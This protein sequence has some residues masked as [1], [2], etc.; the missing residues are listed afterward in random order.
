MNYDPSALATQ[1]DPY[2][3][4]RW[5]L[6]QAPVYENQS[7]GFHALSRFDDVQAAFRDWRTFSSAAGVTV[8]D[9]LEI[10]GPSFLTMDPPR[11]DLLREIVRDAFR[12]A[13]IAAL[14]E[15]VRFHAAVLLDQLESVS[16]LAAAFAG[17]LPVRV[18]CELMGFPVGDELQLKQWSDLVLERVPGDNRAPAAAWEAASAMRSYFREQ[19]DHRR[20]RPASDLV[21]LI[22]A[23]RLDSAPLPL[24]EQLGTCFLLFEAGNSTTKSLLANGSLLLAQHP[25]ERDWLARNPG[26]AASAVE[27]LLR[28]E[29]PVQNM[30]RVTTQGVELHGVK[31]PASSRVL[32]LIGAANRDPRTFDDPDVLDF[33]RKPRRNL[34]FGD[35]IHHCIGA[36]LARL[37]ARVALPALLERFPDYEVVDVERFHDVTQ[38][39]LK[40]LVVQ[41]EH[42]A[43]SVPVA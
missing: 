4:Y 35:G 7:R 36:P 10:T 26:R 6:E 8:D 27:E 37:E 16:D 41:L 3:A 2:P 13:A 39:N 30:G 23:A 14:E 42:R 12:P 18:I 24:E 43:A 17:R 15:R 21:G 9:L 32:L 34:A 1:V 19:L 5:L 11:H 31:I 22:A 29:S 20:R 33:G 28:F 40:R 25:A 38:R